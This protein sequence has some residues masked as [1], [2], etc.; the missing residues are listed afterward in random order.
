MYN[1]TKSL[2]VVLLLILTFAGCKDDKEI[3]PKNALMHDGRE[4]EISKGL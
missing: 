3:E 4:F 1:F 2:C